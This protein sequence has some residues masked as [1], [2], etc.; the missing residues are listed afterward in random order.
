MLYV[1]LYL[2]I[3][4]LF[5]A[6]KDGGTYRMKD[7]SGSNEIMML[8]RIKRWHR[9]GAFIYA[10]VTLPLIFFMHN[11]WIILYAVIIRLVF[12]DPAFN[13]WGGLPSIKYLGST[14]GS[15]S[16]SV[17]IFGLN[18]AIKKSLTFA[19]TLVVTN[20]VLSVFKLQSFWTIETS[21]FRFP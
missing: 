20:I 16:L 21:L 18:G 13:Y 8:K 7:R 9:D 19:A 3:I 11:Y 5:L 14:A 10:L 2:T 17:K 1:Q 15:D 6:G 12:Y 4:I